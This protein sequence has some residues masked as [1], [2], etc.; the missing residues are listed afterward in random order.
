MKK[1]FCFLIFSLSLALFSCNKDDNEKRYDASKIIVEVIDTSATSAAI[2]LTAKE[3]KG[4]GPITFGLCFSSSSE[5]TILNDHVELDL[6]S[7]TLS[8]AD[9]S[10]FCFL[11]DLTKAKE[12]YA[13]GYIKI[14]SDIYYSKDQPFKTKNNTLT[15]TVSDNYIPSG[16]EYWMVLSNKST[17]IFVQRLYNNQT[18][19]NS[20]NIPDKADFHL[21]KWD[22]A[23][24][25][26]FVES[27]TDII[28][29][30][31]YL[32]NPYSTINL[33]QV[34]VT[35]SDLS[36]FLSWGIASS[37]WL[38]TTT[39]G[40]TKTL[41]TAISK[42]PDNLFINYIPSNGPAPLYKFV[43]NVTPNSNYTYTKA[44]FTAMTNFASVALPANVSFT[45]YLAGFNTDYYTEYKR[46]H[47]YSY[48]NGFQGIFKLY[49]PSGINTNYYFYS[50]YNTA[51][52]Q[53][54]YNKLGPLPT[55]YFNTFPT[56]TISNSTQFKTTT[57]GIDSYSKYE[58]MDF[59][60]IYSNS[61]LNIQWDYYKKPQALNSIQIPEFPAEVK[62]KINN[63]TTNDLSFSDVG[64][65]DILESEVNS[66][67][68]YVD[69]LV[70]ESERFYDVI[71]E[72]RYYFQWVNKKSFDSTTKSYFL[73]DL[74]P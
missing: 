29:D 72:R 4:L 43:T 45:Y 71:K 31:F 32:T 37:W 48:Q 53:S 73:P 65:F 13:K 34:N 21:F 2:F 14:A 26:L 52:Q 10:M 47:N 1:H 11:T 8:E 30:E 15:V 23:I 6:N 42:N 46:Y 39:N 66:Y 9:L 27:Y 18:Y 5:P 63:I 20:N 7:D 57:S 28:P 22:P 38:N 44:D 36:D 59:C 19:I 58:I 70:K 49:Y 67:E 35:V 56:I 50:L 74:Q 16:K 25:K 69:L 51:N 24:N 40:T 41:T 55:T 12:Y 17:T 3:V 68:S 54:F 64:Y 33:G 62:L 60:G 61:G